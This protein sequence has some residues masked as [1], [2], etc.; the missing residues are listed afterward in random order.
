LS[1]QSPPGQARRH[2]LPHVDP[3]AVAAVACGGVLGA[4]ARHGLAVAWPHDGAGVPWATLAANTL[5]CLL[6]GALVVVLAEAAA[7]PRLA[8]PFLGVGVLGG[9]TTFS[10][11]A[12]EVQQLAEHGHG[13]VALAYVAATPV[14]ALLAVV[15]GMVGA[16]LGVRGLRR[17][18]RGR[19]AT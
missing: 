3:R 17:A 13:P 6:I 5:G 11:Y 10:T 16:R 4:L 14:A 1:R 18:G 7:P 8:R 19:S 15:A 12:V 2:P 9:F